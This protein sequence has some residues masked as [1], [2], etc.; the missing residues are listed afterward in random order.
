MSRIG[1]RERA[2]QNRV[3]ALFRNSAILDYQYYGDWQ[4]RA[5][6]SNIEEFYLRDWLTKQGV[7]DGLIA[8]AIRQFKLAASMGDG[9]KLYYA[10]QEVYGLLR[11]GVKVRQGQGENTKTVWLI[12]WKNPRNTPLPKKLR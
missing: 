7:D 5:D 4:D 11:Y 2:T 9:K 10:N 1:Q 8:S 6:N 12:D 3:V